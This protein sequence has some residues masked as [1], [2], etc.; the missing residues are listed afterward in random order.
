MAAAFRNRS[1]FS[2]DNL[3]LYGGLLDIVAVILSH[4]VPI[5][6]YELRHVLCAPIGIGGVG[7]AAATARLI[8]GPRA[9]LIAAI[10]LSVC[11]A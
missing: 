3:Y 11:G 7:A 6:P 2:F 4:L 1:L 8:A 10:A 9:G 5:D